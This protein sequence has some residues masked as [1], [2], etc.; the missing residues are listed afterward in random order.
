MSR[1]V[2]F[3]DQ[4]TKE[5]RLAWVRSRNQAHFRNE[6][7]N[8]SFEEYCLLWDTEDLWA[9]RGRGSEDLVLLRTDITKPWALDNCCIVLRRLHLGINRAR[10]VGAS[11]DYYLEGAIRRV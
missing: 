2:K 6:G 11:T 10:E 1:P 5:R 8:L 7:W 4:F 9:R 3:K